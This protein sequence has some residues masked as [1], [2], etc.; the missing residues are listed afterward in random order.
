MVV[1]FLVSTV[2]SCRQTSKEY[3][4]VLTGSAKPEV[5]HL[6]GSDRTPLGGPPP[7][8]PP[9]GAPVRPTSKNPRFSGL[10][11][12]AKMPFSGPPPGGGDF[13]QALL[14]GG[15]PPDLAALQGRRTVE[16]TSKPKN[17]T[18]ISIIFIA[19]FRSYFV[20]CRLI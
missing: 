4:L 20:F 1:L 10:I 2:V 9:R 18:F 14:K 19:F 15:A 8:G 3:D 13:N 7:G 16:F 6:Q 12:R 17:D 5:V 11:P